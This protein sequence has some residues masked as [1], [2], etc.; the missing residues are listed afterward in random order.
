MV[1][2]SSQYFLRNVFFRNVCGTFITL[3][4]KHIFLLKL[5]DLKSLIYGFY[6]FS[7]LSLLIT[8]SF[9][10]KTDNLLKSIAVV[11]CTALNYIR[12]SW[13]C[14]NLK[15]VVFLI[16]DIVMLV[17]V[18]FSSIMTWRA[19]VCFEI[20]TFVFRLNNFNFFKPRTIATRNTDMKI[21][22]FY[23]FSTTLYEFISNKTQMNFYS[24]F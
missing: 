18:L 14:I 20:K 24:T 1:T 4:I 9:M 21:S 3:M 5:G 19:I 12:F 6:M 13:Y 8:S 22:Y 16:Y 11:C 15:L 2:T 10:I 7:F 17:F 23:F